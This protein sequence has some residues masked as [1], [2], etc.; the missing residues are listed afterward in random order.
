MKI[1][2]PLFSPLPGKKI[3]FPR[4]H[5]SNIFPPGRYLFWPAVESVKFGEKAI[6]KT[7]GINFQKNDSV[8][9]HSKIPGLDFNFMFG[10]S[11]IFIRYSKTT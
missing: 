6:F 5:I 8:F 11:F 1:V 4:V 3:L 7:G 2:S 10:E 9:L